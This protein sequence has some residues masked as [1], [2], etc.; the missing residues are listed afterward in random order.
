MQSQASRLIETP[1][2]LFEPPSSD[3]KARVPPEVYRILVYVEAR[4]IQR[5]RFKQEASGF[6]NP[7]SYRLWLRKLYSNVRQ[8]MRLYERTIL[9]QDRLRLVREKSMEDT[10][11]RN[12]ALDPMST[13]EANILWCEREHESELLNDDELAQWA[14][15]PIRGNDAPPKE[16]KRTRETAVGE[17]YYQRQN[18]AKKA[19]RAK[20]RQAKA[21][22]RDGFV[23]RAPAAIPAAPASDPSGGSGGDGRQPRARK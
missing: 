4:A 10:G 18:T 5:A 23:R 21:Q 16:K 19:R 7:G 1:P 6:F 14:S 9:K 15:L 13:E 2:W 22:A 12:D 3:T 17:A 11:V 8:R 20:A